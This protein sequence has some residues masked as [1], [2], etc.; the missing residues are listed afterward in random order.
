MSIINKINNFF[1]NKLY[2]LLY[3]AK[4]ENIKK[5]SSNYFNKKEQLFFLIKNEMEK[6]F[7]KIEEINTHIDSWEE[8]TIEHIYADMQVLKKAF[9]KIRLLPNIKDIQLNSNTLSYDFIMEQGKASIVVDCYK[10]RL[11][12]WNL[13]KEKSIEILNLCIDEIIKVQGSS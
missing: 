1:S 2:K 13:S 3:G 7:I 8:Y 11:I 5:E 4:L 6:P 10:I 12:A 9:I